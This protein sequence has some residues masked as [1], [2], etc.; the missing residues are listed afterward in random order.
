MAILEVE[1][2]HA[3][4]VTPG[5]THDFLSFLTRVPEE[6]AGR[7]RSCRGDTEKARR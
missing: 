6:I 2:S 7:D 4:E 1:G 3:R 5:P